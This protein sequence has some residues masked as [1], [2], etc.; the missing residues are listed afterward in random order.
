MEFVSHGFSKMQLRQQQ[1]A[2]R[3]LNLQKVQKPIPGGLKLE[4]GCHF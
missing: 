4:G 2:K 3:F 1:M